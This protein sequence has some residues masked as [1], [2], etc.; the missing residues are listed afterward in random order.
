MFIKK[1]SKAKPLL[2]DMHMD[3]TR[4]DPKILAALKA[5]KANQETSIDKDQKDA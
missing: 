1:D 3:G 5:L 4:F 2:A